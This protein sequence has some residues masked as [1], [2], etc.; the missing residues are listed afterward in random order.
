MPGLHSLRAPSAEGGVRMGVNPVAIALRG[1][2]R[3]ADLVP[4]IVDA[5]ELPR[6]GEMVVLRGYVNGRRCP[7][8]VKAEIAAAVRD[9]P[10]PVGTFDYG[11][12]LAQIR[13]LLNAAVIGIEDDEADLLAGDDGP[14][15]GLA[16]LRLL[17]IWNDDAESDEADPDPEATAESSTSERSSR[18]SRR[19]TARKTG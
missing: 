16:I 5:V 14:T 19:S 6:D 10:H 11:A 15:G 2:I 13:G 18:S 1:P 17:S 9:N 3:V 12:H 8:R 7:S 4:E